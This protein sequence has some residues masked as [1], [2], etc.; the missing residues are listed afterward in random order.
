MLRV[1]LQGVIPRGRWIHFPIRERRLAF[2]QL[3]VGADFKRVDQRPAFDG[4][5][6]V[7]AAAHFHRH[8]QVKLDLRLAFLLALHADRTTARWCFSPTPRRYESSVP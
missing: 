4:N 6:I 8:R 3:P 5:T 2:E 1:E 7:I